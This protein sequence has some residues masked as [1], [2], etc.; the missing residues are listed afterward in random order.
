[1]RHTYR[2]CDTCIISPRVSRAPQG[3]AV[4][5]HVQQ[6]R[7]ACWLSWRAP[8]RSSVF[9]YLLPSRLVCFFYAASVACVVLVSHARLVCNTESGAA[10][11]V[12]DQTCIAFTLGSVIVT[13][14]GVRRWFLMLLPRGCS[15]LA[16][17]KTTSSLRVSSTNIQQQK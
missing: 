13:A 9:S 15:V 14:V 2:H 6:R 12:E 1:M 16:S 10:R 17:S 8:F 11:N 4:D 3:L 7:L 5:R